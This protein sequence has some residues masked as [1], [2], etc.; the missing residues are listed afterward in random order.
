[1][2]HD[3]GNGMDVGEVKDAERDDVHEELL[4]IDAGGNLAGRF[5]SLEDGAQMIDQG[6]VGRADKFGVGEVTTGVAVLVHDELDDGRV[7]LDTVEHVLDQAAHG[8][9]RRLD[10]GGRGIGL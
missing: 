8:L 3:G 9:P 4:D 7:F 2:V 10:G 6:I 1:A 5:A